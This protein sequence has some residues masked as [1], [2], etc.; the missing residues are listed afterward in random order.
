MR[1]FK[2]SNP[3]IPISNIR[4]LYALFAPIWTTSCRMGFEW[5]VLSTPPGPVHNELR[6]IFRRVIG[7]QSVKQYDYL[8]EQEA[9][10]YIQRIAGFSGDPHEITQEYVLRDR[11]LLSSTFFN[12]LQPASFPCSLSLSLSLSSSRQSLRWP[13]ISILNPCRCV[14]GV[15]VKLAYGEDIHRKYGTE[16][17]DLN[18]TSLTLVTWAFSQAWLP[19]IFPI[20][21]C[22][23]LSGLIRRAHE[24]VNGLFFGLFVLTSFPL[25]LRQRNTYPLGFLE[26][27]STLMHAK[28]RSY[29]SS[30]GI[31]LMAWSSKP[32]WDFFNIRAFPNL[33]IFFASLFCWLLML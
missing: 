7:A 6:K 25:L 33:T 27:H 26:C 24:L 8:I 4:M 16:L 30:F 3:T 22:L 14:G 5:S 13:L 2:H 21:E 1:T 28:D 19:N 11:T 29:L 23:T 17:I 15:V 32:R 20:S 31:G 9:A 12:L 18:T 10:S